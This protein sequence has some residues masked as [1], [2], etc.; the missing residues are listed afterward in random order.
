[1]QH[2]LWADS[3]HSEGFSM[4]AQY[5]NN[6]NEDQDLLDQSKLV[7][8][9]QR[10]EI[11]WNQLDDLWKQAFEEP[12]MKGLRVYFDHGAVAGVP[13]G[14]YVDPQR[15]LPSRWVLTNK[16][17]PTDLSQAQ[18]KARWVFGGHRDPDAGKYPT[19][20]PT[21]S[22]LGHNLLNFIAV[23]KKWIVNYED[24]SAAFLQGQDFPADREIFVRVPRNCPEGAMLELKKF[25]GYQCRTDLLKLTQGGFGLPESPRLW[26]LEYKATLQALGG[27]GLKLLPGF[28]VFK[29]EDELIGMPCIHFDDT[30]YAGAAEA[31]PIWDELHR[32]LDFG[33]RRVAAE[34]WNKFC[35]RYEHQ[36]PETLEFE[37]SMEEYCKDI[38]LVPERAENDL[39]RPLT[40][41]ER[42]MISS[43]V[44]Q[45]AWAARQCRPDLA[46]GCSH[47]QQLAG[48]G[49]ASALKW[50]NRVTRRAKQIGTFKVKDLRC[51][52]EDVVVLSISDASYAGQP[53]GGSQGGLIVA[54]AAP[55][56]QECEAP[57][58]I[59]EC[60]SSRLQRVVRCSMAAELSMAATAFE[61]GD[62]VR[63]TLAEIM[64]P[65][66]EMRR[67]KM[68]A[69]QWRHILVMDANVAY[70]ALQSDSPPTM[71]IQRCLLRTCSPRKAFRCDLCKQLL[72]VF[73]MQ[74]YAGT[75]SDPEHVFHICLRF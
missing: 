25:V 46:Y 58:A 7:T 55:H 19:A 39:S 1:M 33:K 21:V 35:G 12:I 48:Q 72:A 24:V 23:Q 31:Q 49:D 45:L 63:A 18:L 14:Q 9:K 22:L 2:V 32:R 40:E 37:Y 11:N 43:V 20:S 61:H 5:K 68:Y 56:I 6:L 4:P 16:G 29:K 50:V 36:D 42:K 59:M 27:I 17:D 34:G 57:L 47:V 60:Q 41:I 52:L 30:R 65:R 51:K 8:G 70:D 44:G 26:Y 67:W 66:F 53:G 73:D 69:S 15:V 74:W 38:K 64:C 10:V 75:C 54:L 71:R 13:E 28:F 62:H 3:A